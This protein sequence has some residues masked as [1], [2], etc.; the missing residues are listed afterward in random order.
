M[1]PDAA[2]PRS[3]TCAEGY[4]WA[5]ACP[6]HRPGCTALRGDVTDGYAFDRP[7]GLL[8]HYTKAATAFE[9]ILPGRKL[10]MSRYGDMR[11]P[12]ENKDL[13]LGLSFWGERSDEEVGGAFDA[14]LSTVKEIRDS[15]CVLSLCQDA[16]NA[17]DT[18]GCCWARP[19]MWEHYGDVHRGACL[20]FD[21][22]RLRNAIHD[23]IP[24]QLHINEL[25][26][27]MGAVR[28]TPVGIA[29]SAA[30]IADEDL[31]DNTKLRAAVARHI[32]AHYQDFYLLKTDD[33]ATEHEYRIVLRSDTDG[34]RFVDYRDAL[35]AVIV[36]ERFPDWQIAGAGEVCVEAGVAFK[37]MWWERGRPFALDAL[38]TKQSRDRRRQAQ[39]DRQA[40]G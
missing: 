25:P 32:D 31:F 21:A 37:T 22:G 30:G 40:K 19:R 15:M 8:A 39:A 35:V 18:F 23:Q 2:R 5:A 36:G 12:A 26:L 14:V 3:C 11:D 6:G 7:D 13:L 1:G 28:Y 20:V 27:F 29:G 38:S 34:Y 16:P 24:G 17:D 33:W 10:R 4:D 9:H